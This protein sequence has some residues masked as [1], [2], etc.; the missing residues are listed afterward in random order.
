MLGDEL[1]VALVDA[2]A[3]K[4]AQREDLKERVLRCRR[5]NPDMTVTELRRRFG[6][7]LT[8]VKTFIAEAGE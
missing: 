3:H 8:L 2:K 4:L 1:T 7:S 5:H 6:I